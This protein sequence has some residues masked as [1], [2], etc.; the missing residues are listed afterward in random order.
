VPIEGSQTL[1]VFRSPY[2]GNVIFG[3]GE[4]EVSI[5]VEFDDGDGTLVSF[6]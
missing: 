1:P 3:S 4:K 6:E 2:G 5:V